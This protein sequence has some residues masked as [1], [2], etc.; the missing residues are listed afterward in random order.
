MHSDSDSDR[1]MIIIMPV[2]MVMVMV[3]IRVYVTD[4]ALLNTPCVLVTL[5][6]FHSVRS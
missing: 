5:P 6:T 3:K 1:V 2:V 4:D